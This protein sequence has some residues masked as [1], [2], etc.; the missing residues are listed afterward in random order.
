[1]IE[2]PDFV[3]C[4]LKKGYSFWTGV[5]CSVL[6]PL[7]NCVIQEKNLKYI[8]ATSEG[9]A[10]GIAAGAYLAGCKTVVMCQNSGL[11]NTINPLASLNYPFRIP[12]LLIVTHRGEPGKKDEPQHELMGQITCDLLDVLKI[13]WEPFPDTP[14]NIDAVLSR[15]D[16]Y[17]SPK[18]LPFALIL[19]KGSISKFSLANELCCQEI[20]AEVPNGQFKCSVDQR[21]SRLDAIRTVIKNLNGDEAIVATTGKIG[22]E[23]FSMGHKHSQIYI[24]GSMGCASGIGLGI[25]LLLADQKVIVLDGDG[26]A[27]MKLGSLAT[28][29]H[30]KPKGLIHIVLDN[31]A[32]DSTGGQATVSP[33]VDL[34]N[35]ASA[36]GYHNIWRVDT[37]QDLN[38]VIHDAVKLQ[39]PNFLHVKVAPGSEPNLPRPNL[40]PIQV[41]EQFM[42]WIKQHS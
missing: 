24:V 31:E 11:G 26:A 9:E 18:G 14:N 15:A 7:I 22:R 40:S 13:P 29:G 30:Y 10:V 12:T 6:K 8:A 41:K 3:N 2:A 21:I 35:I 34:A 1:M 16:E 17:M 25:N 20:T 32:Y 39:G 42:K 28:I 36:C 19:P 38:Q 27:L 5:P 4:A 37:I 33:T 23:L